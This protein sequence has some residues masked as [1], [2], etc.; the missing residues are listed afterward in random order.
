MRNTSA[1]AD[2]KYVQRYFVLGIP[3]DDVSDSLVERA[4]EDL[5]LGAPDSLAVAEFSAILDGDD[6]QRSALAAE[7][8]LA[9][10][11]I[12]ASE[13]SVPIV[14]YV[15][16][17]VVGKSDVFSFLSAGAV[18][19]RWFVWEAFAVLD[20]RL[21]DPAE[22]R[23]WLG[24]G[25]AMALAQRILQNPNFDIEAKK[26]I[27]EAFL[28]DFDVSLSG[29][30]AEASSLQ[31]FLGRYLRLRR[32]VRGVG[33]LLGVLDEALAEADEQ[34]FAIIAAEFVEVWRAAGSDEVELQFDLDHWREVV[35][36]DLTFS[37]LRRLYPQGSV[38]V[39]SDSDPA[40]E[41]LQIFAMSSLLSAFPQ[42]SAIGGGGR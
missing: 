39:A 16:Q 23:E 20:R 24:D 28:E 8:A 42:T 36:D 38:A 17:R 31:G 25:P 35:S 15:W 6:D 37:S 10:R 14:R 3:D 30:L 29:K 33:S 2:E 21:M 18:L 1:L 12:G 13:A 4:I 22:V 34:S 11:P 41:N 19:S 32:R 26:R 40:P 9:A 7:K 27:S 5:R